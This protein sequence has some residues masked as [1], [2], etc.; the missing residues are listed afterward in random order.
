MS[1]R[2]KSISAIP[3][4]PR[5]S[6]ASSP[7]AKCR[8]ASSSAPTRRRRLSTIVQLDP[9]WVNFNASERDVIAVRA[10]L[11]KQGRSTVNLCCGTPVEVGL[12]TEDGYPHRGKL[13]YVAPRSIL[14]RGRS[15]PALFST[16]PIAPCY[17]DFSCASAFPA[18]RVRSSLCRTLR[19]AAIKP[20]VMSSSSTRTI[21][22]SSAKS[23]RDNSVGDLRVIEPRS[24]QGRP[25]GRRR[26][27][28]GHTGPEGRRRA[29]HGSGREIAGPNR[30]DL[31]IFHRAPGPR[32][33]PRH[34]DDPDR[35]GRGL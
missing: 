32:E 6:M 18:S 1:S 29:G 23:S 24:H 12:Q 22:S 17:R 10:P 26:H 20:A 35:G 33:C 30:D 11:A 34:P 19:S 27:H 25:R 31:K 4:S 3:T 9:I 5:R 15:P 28:A 2:P 14:R 16:M 8:S 13:D 7:R 21:L